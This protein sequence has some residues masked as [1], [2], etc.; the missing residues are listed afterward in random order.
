LA[1]R[2]VNQLGLGDGLASTEDSRRSTLVKNLFGVGSVAALQLHR[3]QSGDAA[4]S[5]EL[6]R[7]FR[8]RFIAGQ[9]TRGGDARRLMTELAA[10]GVRS[11]FRHQAVH[12]QLAASD[13]DEAAH[14]L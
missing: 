1:S 14:A 11:L 5:G 12:R 13:G 9:R 2:S 6:R 8:I 10:D 4:S 3:G 7:W